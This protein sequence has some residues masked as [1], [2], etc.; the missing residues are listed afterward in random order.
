MAAFTLNIPSPIKQ[1]GS[2]TNGSSAWQQGGSTTNGSSAWQQGTREGAFVQALDDV[3]R[4]LEPLRKAAEA[5]QRSGDQHKANAAQL[6]VQMA[7]NEEEHKAALSA[8]RRKIV[9]A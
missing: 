8:W 9:Q 7:V 3:V 6:K 1:G 4:S 5:S 2:T